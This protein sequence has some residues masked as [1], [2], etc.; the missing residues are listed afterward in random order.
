M[1]IQKLGR[2]VTSFEKEKAD[3]MVLAYASGPK[4]AKWKSLK[5]MSFI[6]EGY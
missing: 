5:G 6:P 3:M 1:K 2:R 4:N